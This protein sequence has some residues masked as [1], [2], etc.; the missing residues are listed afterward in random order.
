MEQTPQLQNQLTDPVLLMQSLDLSLRE[1][2]TALLSSNLGQLELQTLR[3]R[4]LCEQ[5]RSI[6]SASQVPLN[7]LIRVAQDCRQ[8]VSLQRALLKRL[9]RGLRLLMLFR[10]YQA[11][12]YEPPRPA[13]ATNQHGG[14]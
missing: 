7:E 11:I 2:R 5:I 8:A 12:T 6:F 10:N 3:Q 4:E 1:A 14:K 13:H 9:Q